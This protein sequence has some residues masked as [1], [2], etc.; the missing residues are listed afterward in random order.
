MSIIDFLCPQFLPDDTSPPCGCAFM[1]VCL[2]II[3]VCF[4]FGSGLF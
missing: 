4:Y 1:A 3:A 2:V